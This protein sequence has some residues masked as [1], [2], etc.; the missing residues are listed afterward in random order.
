[1]FFVELISIQWWCW[2]Y[3]ALWN[4]FFALFA[5]NIFISCLKKRWLG[6]VIQERFIHTND[7]ENKLLF[8]ENCYLQAHTY[9][10]HAE[11]WC[12]IEYSFSLNRK[13]LFLSKFVY[14]VLLWKSK[15]W[16]AQSCNMQVTALLPPNN[17][18]K[19]F[20][21]FFPIW[22]VCGVQYK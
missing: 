9:K 19:I 21:S 20:P 3:K 1:M 8:H 14:G 5:G 2:W 11:M 4:L 15:L 7:S 6:L 18:Y 10:I 17:T 13:R 16:D 12:A 22:N